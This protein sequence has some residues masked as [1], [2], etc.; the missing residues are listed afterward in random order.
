MGVYDEMR[1]HNIDHIGLCMRFRVKFCYVQVG[2]Y[3][4]PKMAN[5]TQKKKQFI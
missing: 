3:T 1:L 2:C 5:K 4:K